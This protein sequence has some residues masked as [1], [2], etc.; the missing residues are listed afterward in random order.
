MDA[1][2]YQ[3]ISNF[4][5]I[6]NVSKAVRLSPAIIG[7]AYTHP[8]TQ[9]SNMD[10]DDSYHI[11]S[12]NGYT[13]KVSGADMHSLWS[14]GDKCFY[15][16]GDKLYRVKSDLT[17]ELIRSN[18]T[19]GAR[20][21]YAPFNDRAY[22]TNGYQIGW[23]SKWSG[24]SIVDPLLEFKVPLPAGQLIE[25][26]MGCLYVAVDNVLYVSDPLCDYYDIRHGYRVFSDRITMLRAVDD[27]I[28]VSDKKA[29]FLSGKSND[30]FERRAAYPLPAIS[31]TDVR[32]PG[33]NMGDGISGN[34]ALW[35][36]ED[37]ICLGDNAGRVL[38]LTESK[39]VLDAH[40]RG[41]AYIR[42]ATNAKH[43]INS[44]Y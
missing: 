13:L 15:V 37:G 32:V 9:A 10:I 44:L 23:E 28:Y 41:A 40:V 42:T 38:N 12:R 8:L 35:T 43:Y 33:S 36:A 31:F 24:N 11:S 39:Y 30:E 26:F 20:M 19:P 2:S 34:V 17:V 29:W 3:T 22:F 16:D 4:S 5:G 18:L 25:F 7:H 1:L 27:G 14:D 21:S 6:N